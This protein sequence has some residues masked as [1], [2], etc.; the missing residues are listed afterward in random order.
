MLSNLPKV[1]ELGWARLR[2][3]FSRIPNGDLS[4]ALPS[5]LSKDRKWKRKMVFKNV[6]MERV[7]KRLHFHLTGIYEAHNRNFGYFVFKS[8]CGLYWKVEH[9]LLCATT[10]GSPVAKH[11]TLSKAVLAQPTPAPNQSWPPRELSQLTWTRV[12]LYILLQDQKSIHKRARPIVCS[13][14]CLCNI[15][16][17]RCFAFFLLPRIKWHRRFQ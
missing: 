4:A 13:A 16:T 17:K 1:T 5:F 15:G 2:T 3:H 8:Y 14:W 9:M 6:N 10:W 11:P 12:R 7:R